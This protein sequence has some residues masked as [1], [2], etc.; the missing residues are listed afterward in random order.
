[1]VGNSS[2][3]DWRAEGRP[4]GSEKQDQADEM[5]GF[6]IVGREDFSESTFLLEIRHPAMAKAARPV[7]NRVA[8]SAVVNACSAL[9][10][11]AGTVNG[12]S[13]PGSV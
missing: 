12:C 3:R 9:K 4:D 11:E 13:R 1:M 6:E 7:M 2:D 5:S 8:P 10:L